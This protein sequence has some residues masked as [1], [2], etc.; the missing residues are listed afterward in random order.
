M[1]QLQRPAAYWVYVG[2]YTMDTGIHLFRL[3]A[4]TGKMEPHG[5]AA[6][7]G[8][9]NFQTLSP[10]ERFL[11]SN[12]RYQPAADQRI[13]H[14]ASFSIDRATGQL[15]LINEQASGGENPCFI[16]IDSAGK[17]VLVSHYESASVAVL[18]IDSNGRLAAPSALM[19]QRGS[20]VHPKRQTH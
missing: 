17:N 20:S 16:T 11:Y 19:T 18:P 3:D 12:I 1:P 7:C 9:P 5:L 4:A 15:T 14:V 2:S 13:D 10:D 8:R 6:R